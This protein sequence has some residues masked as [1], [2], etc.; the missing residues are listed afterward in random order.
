[1]TAC[2]PS[3]GHALPARAT[4]PRGRAALPGTP[5]RP[6]PPDLARRSRPLAGRAR[7]VPSRAARTT[8]ASPGGWHRP[9]GSLRE[10]CRPAPSSRPR[11]SPRCRVRAG[12][13]SLAGRGR[14][15][16][17]ALRGRRRRPPP[18]RRARP[19]ARRPSCARAWRRRRRRPGPF[20]VA[21]AR[22]RGTARSGR[23]RRCRTSRSAC[24]CERIRGAVER[25]DGI[26]ARDA[27]D[28]DV[29]ADALRAGAFFD[30]RR[31]V[32]RDVF[33]DVRLAA[34]LRLVA[35]RLAAG[36]FFA[37]LVEFVELLRGVLFARVVRRFAVFLRGAAFA[38][39]VRFFAGAFRGRAFLAWIFRALELRLFDAR[40][41]AYA[42]QGS[43]SYGSGGVPAYSGSSSSA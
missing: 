33:A 25:F 3:H 11:P 42:A 23:S 7:S 20:R 37:F 35:V 2:M 14:A 22:T 41:A 8:G 16:R 17:T 31:F 40:A 30:A 6:R 39:V 26:Q 38:R 1:M 34:G 32:V 4:P 27:R 19:D 24:P 18:L 29:R 36:R 13:E 21:P 10:A 43:S 5:G 12:L 9:A 28:L 15:P